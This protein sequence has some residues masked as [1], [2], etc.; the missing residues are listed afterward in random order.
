MDERAQRQLLGTPSPA[1]EDDQ[2]MKAFDSMC[3]TLLS[4]PINTRFNSVSH[5]YTEMPMDDV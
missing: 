1:L 5:F 4:A 2:I 3:P